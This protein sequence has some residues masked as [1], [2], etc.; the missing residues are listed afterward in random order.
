[1]PAASSQTPPAAAQ[2]S[3]FAGTCATAGPETAA[4]RT[5]AMMASELFISLFPSVMFGGFPKPH[6]L[7]PLTPNLFRRFLKGFLR[8]GCPERSRAT[9]R[10]VT[11]GRT[12]PFPEN[13]A[14][15]GG[16]WLLPERFRRLEGYSILSAA[17][18]PA[19]CR[20]SFDGGRSNRQVQSS[21]RRRWQAWSACARR[22]SSNAAVANPCS[23]RPMAHLGARAISCGQWPKHAVAPTSIR[24]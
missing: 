17:P 10:C 18:R 1:M 23:S 6:V 2:S 15:K 5:S 22:N 19:Q 11:P 20:Q 3:G 14:G 12:A 9:V 16:V 13:P 4:A 24:R 7:G 8:V 21:P